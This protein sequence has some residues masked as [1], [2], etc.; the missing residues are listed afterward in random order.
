MTRLSLPGDMVVALAAP[1]VPPVRPVRGVQVGLAVARA[2]Q[3]EVAKRQLGEVL[4]ADVVG[5]VGLRGPQDAADPV[6]Q[7]VSLLPSYRGVGQCSPDSSE[8]Q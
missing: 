4:A 6:L 3:G 1:G 5:R 7:A 8:L 2:R